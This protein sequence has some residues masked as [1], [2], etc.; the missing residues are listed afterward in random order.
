MYIKI[1]IF[2]PRIHVCC[3]FIQWKVINDGFIKNIWRSHP[4][5]CMGMMT[6]SVYG[7]RN[8][9]TFVFR[10][11]VAN[12]E[13][14]TMLEHTTIGRTCVTRHKDNKNMHVCEL[15]CMLLEQRVIWALSVLNFIRDL[16]NIFYNIVSSL[17]MLCK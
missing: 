14:S 4:S 12:V 1:Y 9:F 13:V 16:W 15:M 8:I 17:E 3:N 11:W 5:K 7:K 6:R 2:L 10:A